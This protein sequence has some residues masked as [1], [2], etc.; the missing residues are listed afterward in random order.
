M[1]TCSEIFFLFL[2]LIEHLSGV[3]HQTSTHPK[4]LQRLN[5]I[6]GTHDEQ[7]GQLKGLGS[8][9]RVVL[10]ELFRINYDMLTS[11]SSPYANIN[12]MNPESWKTLKDEYVKRVLE[13]NMST[14]TS[15]G[16][17]LAEDAAQEITALS[18]KWCRDRDDDLVH[19]GAIIH[20]DTVLPELG[21]IGGL[22]GGI[23]AVASL[24]TQIFQL[25]KECTH[26]NQWGPDHLKNAIQNE[27]LKHDIRTC[28]CIR[29]LKCNS[30][31]RTDG[32]LCDI[33]LLDTEANM[34]CIISLT[35]DSAT[36]SLFVHKAQ[37]K[38]YQRFNSA[39]W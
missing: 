11:P 23:A 8:C 18:N 36:C 20:A 9:M 17:Y 6:R 14:H 1:F 5:N 12:S 19:I 26:G 39:D 33:M 4:A 37:R 29:I 38:G 3:S 25:R 21:M 13:D 22:I 31:I 32:D 35:I 16:G 24:C 30:E 34:E 10:D 15:I 27:I 28:K 2:H 7:A